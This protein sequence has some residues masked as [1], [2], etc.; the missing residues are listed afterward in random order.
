M[1]GTDLIPSLFLFL[2]CLKSNPEEYV[3]HDL[4]RVN[5]SGIMLDKKNP[6]PIEI[7]QVYLAEYGKCHDSTG[8]LVYLCDSLVFSPFH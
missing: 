3:L 2:F 1:H 5:Y 8:Q 4:K 6:N 7:P